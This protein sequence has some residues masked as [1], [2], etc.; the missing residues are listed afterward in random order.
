MD[1]GSEQPQGLTALAPTRAIVDKL[2]NPRNYSFLFW[3]MGRYLFIEPLPYGI[4]LGTGA[5]V[6][7]MI[8]VKWLLFKVGRRNENIAY[9]GVGNLTFSVL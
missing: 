5:A 1:L 3:K 9:F 8:V 4:V 7:D 2:L 6:K